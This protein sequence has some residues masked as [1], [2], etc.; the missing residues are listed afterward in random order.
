MSMIFLRTSKPAGTSDFAPIFTVAT[1]T[2]RSAHSFPGTG[3]IRS[4]TPSLANS[5][6][7]QNITGG[8][9][10]MT[11]RAREH[12]QMP[13]GVVEPQPL[14]RKKRNA[15]RVKY[16]ASDEPHERAGVNLVH[17][18]NDGDQRQPSHRQIER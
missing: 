14:P 10:D 9:G 7:A 3:S 2:R 12:E 11:G 1:V 8:G 13:D 15:R 5:T 16:T 17:Q 4:E 18:G 6:G